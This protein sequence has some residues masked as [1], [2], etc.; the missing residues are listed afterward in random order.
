MRKL[1]KVLAPALAAIMLAGALSGCGGARQESN[2][3]APLDAESAGA[4]Y[5]YR[6]CFAFGLQT[7]DFEEMPFAVPVH[8]DFSA[9]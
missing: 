9:D 7:Y 8:G 1:K 4:S 2:S 5:E 6:H 3:L